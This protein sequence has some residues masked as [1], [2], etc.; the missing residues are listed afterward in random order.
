MELKLGEEYNRRELQSALGEG[1]RMGGIAVMKQNKQI[2][3]FSS[4]K[5]EAHGYQDGWDEAKKYFYYTGA[6][7]EGDQD[8]ES[9]RH[10]GHI[11]HHQEYEVSVRLMIETRSG[12]HRYEAELALVDYQYF[13]T[14]DKNGKNRKAVQFIFENI[15]ELTP[16]PVT[17]T[18]PTLYKK[19]R[20]YKS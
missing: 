12:H 19:A 11:L 14:H 16:K 7:Q 15:A 20:R 8:I 18:T 2:L 9:P 5:G 6:G 1:S 13:D 10:N 17:S 4:E 3:I